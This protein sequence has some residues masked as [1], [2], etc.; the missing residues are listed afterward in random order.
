MCIGEKSTLERNLPEEKILELPEVQAILK[1]RAEILLG[2]VKQFYEAIITSLPRLPYGMRWICKQIQQIAAERFPNSTQS[3]ILRVTGYII[4]YRFINVMIVQPADFKVVDIRDITVLSTKNLVAV[5]KVLQ[6]LFS[7]STFSDQYMQPVN[8][9]LSE[10]MDRTRQYLEELLDVP[11]PEDYL[12]V[13]R[14][15]ELTQK[16]KP[17]IIISLHEIAS[18][19]SLIH[20][21]LESLGLEKDDPLRV[22]MRDLDAFGAVPDIP[23]E[24]DREMQLTLSSRFETQVDE[25]S[26]PDQTLFAE[27]KE[28]TITALRGI[29]VEPR[30]GDQ[31]PS[32]SETLA[33]GLA[34]ADKT[35]N[36]SLHTT[37]VKVQENLKKLE[38]KNLASSADNYASFLRA[39]ALEVANRQSIREQQKK[40]VKRLEATLKNLRSHQQYI[41]DQ[42]KHYQD[43]LQD[44]KAKQSGKK[45]KKT[46]STVKKFKFTY[47]QLKKK[48]SPSFL[49]LHLIIYL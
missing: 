32:F 14:Y 44:C 1:S 37:I 26:N 30:T 35:G 43:Y 20:K 9:W 42:I 13:D 2:M 24:D 25:D 22:I 29:P 4:Y 28:L 6:Q 38:D 5:A 17:V 3:E 47:K 21:H 19:H 48:V 16:T 18:T 12:R 27:T 40:E 15:V 11:E 7:L 8:E 41:N 23:K 36:S 34:Y 45:T 39:V 33:R 31:A 46:S 10:H 49:V